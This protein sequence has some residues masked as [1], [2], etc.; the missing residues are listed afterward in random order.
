M[1]LNT[2]EKTQFMDEE[3]C[4]GIYFSHVGKKPDVSIEKYVTFLSNLLVKKKVFY[5]RKNICKT[6]LKDLFLCL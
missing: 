5:K 2:I 1:R 4:S 6:N 3:I